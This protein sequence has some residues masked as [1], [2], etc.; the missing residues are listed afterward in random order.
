MQ[1]WFT[2]D[3]TFCHTTGKVNDVTCKLCGGSGE[4]SILLPTEKCPNCAG[5][6]ELK[7]AGACKLCSGY[8]LIAQWKLKKQ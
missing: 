7:P 4:I 5:T 8:G 6:G 2:A 3:C 1:R